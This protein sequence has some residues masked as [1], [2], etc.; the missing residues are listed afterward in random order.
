MPA[1]MQAESD[2]GPGFE[3]RYGILDNAYVKWNNIGGVAAD[4][5][6]RPPGYRRLATHE[7]VAGGGRHAR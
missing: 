2:D 7:L 1:N 6:R 5:L 3:E 4:P